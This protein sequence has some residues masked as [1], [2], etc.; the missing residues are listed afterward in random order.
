MT[1][2]E[3][4]R[5][6]RRLRPGLGYAGLDATARTQARALDVDVGQRA[7]EPPWQPPRLAAEERH[8]GGDEHHAHDEGVEQDG[9]GQTEPDE[10][11]HR[12]ARE[13]AEADEHAD[14]DTRSS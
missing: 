4:G 1:S 3:S 8:D 10:R 12:V 9:A 5:L 14:H 7:L 11:D 2:G 6:L 13:Q